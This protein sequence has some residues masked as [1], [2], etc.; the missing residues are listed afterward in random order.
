M[1][2]KNKS[3]R[4]HIGKISQAIY[5]QVQ[6]TSSQSKTASRTDGVETFLWTI[7]GEFCVTK[8]TTIPKTEHRTGKRKCSGDHCRTNETRISE[9]NTGTKTKN[10]H[11]AQRSNIHCG[12]PTLEEQE[13]PLGKTRNRKN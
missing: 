1:A 10:V 13:T 9:L 4:P 6:R 5:Q 12:R 3:N 2:R 8:N 11:G 7:N